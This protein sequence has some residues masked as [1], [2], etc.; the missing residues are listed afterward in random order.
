[1]IEDRLEMLQQITYSLEVPCPE[2]LSRL[3]GHPSSKSLNLSQEK[4]LLRDFE[5]LSISC[6]VPVIKVAYH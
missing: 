4:S 6:R 3:L 1:M 2:R 5:Y